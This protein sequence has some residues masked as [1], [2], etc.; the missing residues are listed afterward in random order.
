MIAGIGA[1]FIFYLFD[2]LHTGCI[3]IEV[4]MG[5]FYLPHSPARWRQELDWALSLKY[6]TINKLFI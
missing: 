4:G 6:C 2:I 1:G 3:T 5:M